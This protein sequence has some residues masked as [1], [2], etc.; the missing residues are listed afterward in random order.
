M[1]LNEKKILFI[2]ALA[3]GHIGRCL[4][5]ANKISKNSKIYFSG[6]SNGLAEKIISNKYPFI[7]IEYQK[8]GDLCFANNLLNII[9]NL[10]PDVICLDI[11]PLPWLKYVN[12]TGI[13]QIFITNFFLTQ[14][15]TRKTLQDIYFEQHINDINLFREK[16]KL[17]L[18]NNAREMYE[19]EK[20]ILC[21]PPF[22]LSQEIKIPSHYHMVGPC[23]WE[24]DMPLPV[25]LEKEENLLLL[26]FGSSG[27]V[28]ISPLII[29]ELAES[30][31]I[32]TVLWM[33]GNQHNIEQ[34][35]LK[36][37]QLYYP[38]LPASKILPKTMLVVSH[39]G[40]GSSYQAMMHGLPV[41][42]WASHK[43]QT[44][45]G[46]ILVEYGCGIFIEQLVKEKQISMNINILQNKCNQFQDLILSSDGPC[47]AAKIISRYL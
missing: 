35:N 34:N 9:Q 46:E 30:L 19:G 43:N 5:I 20:V 3:L 18:W 37:K 25:E 42:I 44:I 11:T 24:P 17:T 12:I 31:N 40:A 41:G 45:L 26:S 21:D 10:K 33:G 32:N 23:C 2:T 6:P 47:T 38:W 16:E 14:L 29:E 39:G 22:L 4:V 8:P 27:T 36:I 13:P 15:G 28:P 1:V 7:K